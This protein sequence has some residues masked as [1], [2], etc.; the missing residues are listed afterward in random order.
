MLRPTF[1]Y[2]LA[3]LIAALSHSSPSSASMLEIGFLNPDDILDEDTFFRSYSLLEINLGGQ[4]TKL[5]VT[6][7]STDTHRIIGDA[8]IF[9][10]DGSVRLALDACGSG[11]DGLLELSLAATFNPSIG[12]GG[13]YIRYLDSNHDFAVLFST[14]NPLAAGDYIS[15]E[16]VNGFITPTAINADNTPDPGLNDPSK[17]VDLNA[18]VASILF[19]DFYFAGYIDGNPSFP[20]LETVPVP[21]GSTY[22]EDSGPI[23]DYCVFCNSSGGL[24]A[25]NTP[26][27]TRTEFQ[28]YFIFNEAVPVS[29]PE[30][31]ISWLLLG[32]FGLVVAMRRRLW[33]DPSRSR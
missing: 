28:F 16:I 2:V 33:Q 6:N 8:N 10:C 3:L 5:Q 21:Q 20:G 17:V 4:V 27:R 7:N 14:A 11:L 19:A 13:A 24:V 15:G 9:I 30:P 12:V 1:A 31:A 26:G 32:G 18:N 29:V 22:T 23:F 25:F